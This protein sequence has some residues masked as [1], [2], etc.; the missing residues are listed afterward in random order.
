MNS[1]STFSAL[2]H[3]RTSPLHSLHP[4]IRTSQPQEEKGPGSPEPQSGSPGSAEA[5]SFQPSPA[6]AAILKAAVLKVKK[7]NLTKDLDRLGSDQAD[8]LPSNDYRRT[9]YLKEHFHHRFVR[10]LK[11]ELEKRP[12]I[13]D[14]EYCKARCEE[15]TFREGYQHGI[16]MTLSI[17]GM[18]IQQ[19]HKAGL[20]EKHKK[21]IGYPFMSAIPDFAISKSN[22]EM[23]DLK[24]DAKILGLFPKK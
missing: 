17:L 16:S 1:Y 11:Q 8:R 3:E 24:L 18:S 7:D 23:L 21:D 10:W 13:A 22:Q 2:W 4:P 20:S 6:S 14:E 19:Y 15:P 9:E 12:S 5:S